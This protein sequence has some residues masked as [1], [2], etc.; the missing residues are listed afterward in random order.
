M[1]CGLNQPLADMRDEGGRC[2]GLTTLPPPYAEYLE[3]LGT[4]RACLNLQWDKKIFY[5]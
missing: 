3:I 1:A 2:V 5:V 4:L